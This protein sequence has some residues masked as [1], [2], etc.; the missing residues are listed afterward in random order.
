MDQSITESSADASQVVEGDDAPERER[1]RHRWL[2][3]LVLTP[4]VLMGLTTVAWAVDTSL[5]G[6]PRNVTLAG[7]DIG[8]LS[9]AELAAR[10]RDVAADFAATRVEIVSEVDT[11]ST[12]TSDIGLMIDEDE[13]ARAAL[14][15]EDH[16][17]VLVRAV[18]W[19][20]SF[21]A[22]LEAP[23]RFRVSDE[24]VA[25]TMSE[26]EGEA[27]TPP[28]EP[29]VE[30]VDGTL[31]VVTGV[32]GM[33]IDP[34]RV[35]ALLPEA[36]AAAGPGE[37]IRVRVEQGPIPPLGS[38]AEA[39]QAASA[40]EAVV[41][42]DI[43]IETS[44][45]SR[46]ITAD[47]LRG[48]V[49]LS[50]LPDGTVDF[51]LDP[52]DVDESLREAFSDV[53]D[54]PADATFTVVDGRPIIRPD[55]PGKVC[56]GNNAAATIESALRSGARTVILELVEGQAAFTVED[57][58]AWGITQPVGGNH[59]WRDGAPTTAAPG[60]TTYHAPTG[61]RV[62]NIHRI[63]DLVRGAVVPPGGSFSINEHVGRRTAAN[64]FVSAG[65]ISN[66]QHVNEIG[67]GISQ[68]ATTTFN[69]VF[70]AGLDIDEY[71][72]HSEYFDRYPLGREATMGYPSPDLKF[73]NNTPYGVLIW[74]SYTDSSLTVTLYSTPY[75]TAEQTAIS[76]GRSGRCR[77][78]TTTR[79][80]TYPDGRTVEDKFRARY[81][82]GEGQSC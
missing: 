8:R 2:L 19:A 64:G 11:Y 52:P 73:T 47:E 27:R 33:G 21:V 20:R 46:T 30:L 34:N 71:Q 23:L 22:P 7:I 43:V 60:F 69:A 36:A 9:E 41:G 74:T 40:A 25:T 78:V 5:G 6:V 70:F 32:D 76:E 16:G 51:R 66:G 45:G 81:R 56:C 63:A 62:I 3:P 38:A 28:T 54:G 67:G 79:T 42:Q 48:W 24:R 29:S 57:A 39:R 1:R 4:L 72:A 59:A 37:T 17:F 68:F 44:D 80:R 15:V 55:R 58:E 13:T 10:V 77:V 65:A 35:A 26:L 75:A 53:E 31:H 82:P 14:D 18:R 49:A 61:A 12:T 50:S